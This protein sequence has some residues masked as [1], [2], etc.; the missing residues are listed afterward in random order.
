MVRDDGV[1][2]GWSQY[3]TM[4]A[5]A[6]VTAVE[7]DTDA[8]CVLATRPPG[9]GDA[10]AYQFRP[11][12]RFTP[13]QAMINNGGVVFVM[14]HSGNEEHAHW[15]PFDPQLGYGSWTAMPNGDITTSGS[16]KSSKHTQ[17]LSLIHI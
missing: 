7:R 5:C 3:K 9:N 11:T 16:T 15:V 6:W 14:S 13:T 1:V 12:F 8:D 4:H 17:H 10:H 2:L